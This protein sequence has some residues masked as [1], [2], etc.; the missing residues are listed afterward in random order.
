MVTAF[1]LAYIAGHGM[2]FCAHRFNVLDRPDGSIKKHSQ[3]V[4]YLGGIAIALG[5]LGAVALWYPYGWTRLWWVTSGLF[6]LLLLGLVDDLRPLGPLQ[7][8]AGQVIVVAFFIAQ[9]FSLKTH[10]LSE[11]LNMALTA[12]WMLTII[13]AF[14]LI[15]VMDGLATTI[16][17]SAAFSFGAAALMT[18]DYQ[19]SLLIAAFI[20]G[21]VGFF[22][23]NKPNAHLYMG[24]AGALFIGGFLSLVPLMQSWSEHTEYGLFVPFIVLALPLI[25]V[26]TLVV[27]RSLKG[28]PFYNGSPHHFS[29]YLQRK[30]WSKYAILGFSLI[31]S[32]FASSVGLMLFEGL[33]GVPV[34]LLAGVLFLAFWVRFVLR[35]EFKKKQ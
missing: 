18:S 32:L 29:L 14:N 2:I 28:I 23:H 16:G 20:G 6:A 5:I 4:P 15:D 7:K 34:V 19:L 11:P 3:P 26:T 9:G 12:F 27:V 21:L 22:I 1:V 31:C 10:F 17:I 33:V 8:F 30:G 13:N 35:E 25:E 24:D